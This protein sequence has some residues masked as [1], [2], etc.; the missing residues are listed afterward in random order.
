[1]Y[2]DATAAEAEN[3]FVLVE[4]PDASGVKPV[5]GKF[6]QVENEPADAVYS[7]D[8]KTKAKK[9]KENK[10]YY[11]NGATSGIFKKGDLIESQTAVTKV[12]FGKDIPFKTDMKVSFWYCAGIIDRGDNIIRTGHNA[13]QAINYTKDSTGKGIG[14]RYG[15]STFTA[16][17]D[18]RVVPI[19][20]T[21]NPRN[22]EF[23]EM[24][25]GTMAYRIGPTV[26]YNIPNLAAAEAANKVEL[27]SDV[28]SRSTADIMPSCGIIIGK[29]T[30][31]GCI[32]LIVYHLF[33]RLA[34]FFAYLTGNIFDF[35][36]GFSISSDA[37]SS[38]FVTA[39]WETVRDIANI[40]FIVLLI[41]VAIGSVFNINGVSKKTKMG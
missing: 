13:L 20:T 21:K 12:T 33:F 34:A 6:T 26:T 22:K 18:E 11:Y 27:Q 28:T 8:E 36:L 35:F 32:A 3:M 37:Y 4:Y 7:V 41:Y 38:S 9:N 2:Y 25:R 29:G 19:D 39:G 10:I 40:F 17:T 23:A 30:F 24:C 1:M 5:F 16:P 15:Y 14:S 31:M